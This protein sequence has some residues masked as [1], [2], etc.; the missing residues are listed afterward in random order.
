MAPFGDYWLAQ[1]AYVEDH[2]TLQRL[3]LGQGTWRRITL[4]DGLNDLCGIDTRWLRVGQFLLRYSAEDASH[5]RVKSQQNWQGLTLLLEEHQDQVLSIES[6]PSGQLRLVAI[7]DCASSSWGLYLRKTDESNY[8]PSMNDGWKDPSLLAHFD[9]LRRLKNATWKDERH[10]LID[11][12]GGPGD[13]TLR[14]EAMGV[15]IDWKFAGNKL[16][17][18]PPTSP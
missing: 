15:K 10:L 16:G 9:F 7:Q 17:P 12:V 3:I 4:I 13:N 6:S 14:R 1:E 2:E 8:L 5:L 18:R 11:V